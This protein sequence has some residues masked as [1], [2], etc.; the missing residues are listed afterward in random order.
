MSP[1]VFVF[2][3]LPARQ[4]DRKQADLAMISPDITPGLQDFKPV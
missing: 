2:P 1:L 4:A 3:N